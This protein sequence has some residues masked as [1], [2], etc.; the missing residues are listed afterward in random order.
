[1]VT[2]DAAHGVTVVEGTLTDNQAEPGS[3][4]R[5]PDELMPEIQVTQNTAEPSRIERFSCQVDFRCLDRK[6]S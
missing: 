2:H 4:M 5:F 3:G 6:G 1:V